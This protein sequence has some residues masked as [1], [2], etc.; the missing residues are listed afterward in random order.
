MSG[1]RRLFRNARLIDPESGLD[2]PGDLLIDGAHIAAIG[3]GL[4]GSGLGEDI[5][6]VEAGGRWADARVVEIDHGSFARRAFGVEAI[7]L[8]DGETV[9][10][11]DVAPPLVPPVDAV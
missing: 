9:R 5:A 8:V 2:A 10:S 6:V 4:A 7:V 11:G 1:A 3:P